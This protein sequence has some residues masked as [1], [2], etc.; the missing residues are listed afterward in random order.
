[1]TSRGLL[2]RGTVLIGVVLLLVLGLA[3]G[4]LWAG[5]RTGLYALGLYRD[6]G[7]PTV[8]PTVFHRP[9]ARSTVLPAA[10][11]APVLPDT[12]PVP[13]TT[14]DEVAARIAALGP[15]QGE[16]FG[17]VID[18]STGQ[19]LYADNPEGV[20][21]PAS[22]LKVLTSLAALEVYGPDHR[23]ATRVL[24]DP[25]QPA[26]LYLVGGGDPYLSKGPAGGPPARSSI[27]DLAAETA[28]ELT[29]TGPVEL[30]V[31][32]SLFAGPGWNPD[33]IPVYRDYV[34]ETSA[35]WVDGARPRGAAIGRRDA[36][37]PQV[38]AD[39]FVAE[40]KRRGVQVGA[41]TRGEAPEVATE[42][43]QVESMPV[44]NIVEQVLIYSDNDAA[45]VLFRHVGR[46]DGRSGSITDAQEAMADV[47]T[48]LGAWSDGMRVVDGSGLS[49]ANRVSAS[50]LTHAV[51]V[52]V[53]PGADRYR[54]IPTGMSVAGVEGTLAGRFVE[55]G[56]QPGRGLVRAKTGTLTNVHSLAGYVRTGDGSWLVYAFVV[57][58]E[59]EEYKTRVWLDRITA[60]LAACG[61]RG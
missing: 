16:S 13:G 4:V 49:R 57:N 10:P 25:T 44:E 17:L 23:F 39:T 48:E 19:T 55:E 14:A 30:V 54:A 53:K 8:D 36:D 28:T 31:D 18:E 59:Q 7:A 11:S 35:L 40:L 12:S 26:R 42:L 60:T 6:G 27:L 1:M 2:L 41:I 22:T 33:W 5:T 29:T 37:P 47:L 34:A 21:V 46:A 45:E 56:T 32:T 52:A 20:A 9:D 61:C 50:S 15:V 58:G 24:R 3:S 43:A 51:Q 38:A